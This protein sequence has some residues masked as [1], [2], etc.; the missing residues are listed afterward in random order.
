[1]VVWKKISSITLVSLLTISIAGCSFPETVNK[2]RLHLIYDTY[3]VGDN[4]ASTYAEGVENFKNVDQTKPD[5]NIFIYEKKMGKFGEDLEKSKNSRVDEVLYEVQKLS[6]DNPVTKAT[7]D[8]Y[9]E[10]LLLKTSSKEYVENIS[11]LPY[12]QLLT[13]YYM[14]RAVNL[15]Y[16]P[17]KEYNPPNTPINEATDVGRLMGHYKQLLYFTISQKKYSNED[18]MF[19]VN[20]RNYC[21]EVLE[22]S[23]PIALKY[24][25]ENNKN[26]YSKDYMP[27][28]YK[29]QLDIAKE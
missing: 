11:S 25:K 21:R 26:I 12:A 6:S 18:F 3:L 23:K 17:E 27:D 2:A 16:E 24:F 29:K 9:L 19:N 10:L 28:I 5:K 20:Y 1:M 13:D 14:I 7:V 4:F 15:Q 8:D 22:V